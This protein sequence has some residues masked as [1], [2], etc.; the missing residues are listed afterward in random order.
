MTVSAAEGSVDSI[1]GDAR[2]FPHR[3]DFRN[4]RYEFI[5]MPREAHRETAFLDAR[6]VPDHV[7]RV[8]V[9]RQAAARAAKPRAPLHFIFHSG[10][11]CSTLM[12]RA[13]DREGSVMGLKEP[14]ILSDVVR[15]NLSG[16]G[17]EQSR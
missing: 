11:A 9:P 12:A 5:F 2:W 16:A 1:L 15:Y 3:F 17:A 10:M 13:L 6:H 7:A 14:I 8:P 4:D